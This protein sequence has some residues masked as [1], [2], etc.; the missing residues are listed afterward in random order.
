MSDFILCQF[1]HH[2][3]LQFFL[4]ISVLILVIS[5]SSSTVFAQ[6]PTPEESQKIRWP[7]RG[8]FGRRPRIP[9]TDLRFSAVPMTTLFLAPPGLADD[10][11]VA[12]GQLAADDF[13]EIAIADSGDDLH[14]HRQDDGNAKVLRHQSHC[15]HALGIACLSY[16]VSGE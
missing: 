15:Q 2:H 1:Q 7:G 16:P 6:N 9:W 13:G 10:D 14:G 8:R 5:F 4:S 12:L 11:L 3:F